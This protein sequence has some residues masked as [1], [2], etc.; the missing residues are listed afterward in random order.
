MKNLT[1][2]LTVALG[3]TATGVCA[4]QAYNPLLFNLS[5]LLDFNPVAGHIKSLDV[6]ATNDKGEVMFEL[7]STLSSDGCVQTLTRTDKFSHSQMVLAKEGHTLKGTLDGQPITFTLDSKCNL[8]S[9]DDSTGHLDYRTNAQGQLKTIML[10]TQKIADHFYDADGN[11]IKAE[12]YAS[13]MV[14]SANSITYPDSVNKPVDY[15]LVN[16][17]A[18]QPGFSATN[19]CQYDK[20][21]VPVRCHL[22]FSPAKGQPAPMPD[23]TVTTRASFY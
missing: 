5:T 14:A 17:S 3:L 7:T 20:Q 23:L 21:H 8:L 9:R 10:G 13:G 4:K 18:L 1:Y 2:L 22:T 19:T 15:T 16:Q 12:F 6:S 11:L